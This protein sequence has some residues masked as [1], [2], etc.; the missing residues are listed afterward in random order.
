MGYLLS[1]IFLRWLNSCVLIWS[2]NSV[3]F[4]KNVQSFVTTCWL[5]SQNSNNVMKHWTSIQG[6][7]KG[8]RNRHITEEKKD[9]LFLSLSPPCHTYKPWHSCGGQRTIL[10]SILLE[11]GP[12]CF[13]GAPGYWIASFND[14]PITVSHLV[15]G[16]LDYQCV[17]HTAA[18]CIWVLMLLQQVLYLPSHLR[19]LGLN[20]H[21]LL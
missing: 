1:D 8:W 7:A 4:R 11:A 12:L 19:G 16:L 20:F 15:T 18:G 9:S 3:P 5:Q 13:L 10:T 17:L 6:R 21:W 2:T 14:S